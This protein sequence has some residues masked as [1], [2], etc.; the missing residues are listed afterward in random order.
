MPQWWALAQASMATT[1]VGCADRND[2]TRPLGSF[3]R[4]MTVPLPAEPWSWKL[5]LARSIPMMVAWSMDASSFMWSP[6]R[7]P[8]HIS[9][10]PG[11]GIHPIGLM[12][13]F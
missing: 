8:W 2:R 4:K 1:H 7:P 13:T 12:D 6:A 10:P 5:C 9:M 3:L 11:G